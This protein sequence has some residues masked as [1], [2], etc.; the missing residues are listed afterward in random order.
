MKFW[1]ILLALFTTIVI[2]TDS[3]SQIVPRSK[4]VTI[5]YQNGSSPRVKFGIDKLVDALLLKGHEVTTSTMI[6]DMRYDFGIIISNPTKPGAKLPK[7]GF[8]IRN[9][10][11]V[12]H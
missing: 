7:E 12:S 8:T 9:W 4:K 2:H 1:R 11:K 5:F 10:E 6:Q 3:Y